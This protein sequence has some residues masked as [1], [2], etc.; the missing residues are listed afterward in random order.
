MVDI[1]TEISSFTEERGC[2]GT[3]ANLLEDILASRLDPA[4]HSNLI[5]I[6]CCEIV[7]IIEKLDAQV[8]E[9]K[10]II[11]N[12]LMNR[13]RCHAPACRPSVTIQTRRIIPTMRT[14]CWIS[15]CRCTFSTAER[16][17][18]AARSF[19][20]RK[21]SPSCRFWPRPWRRRRWRAWWPQPCR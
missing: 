3:I 8:I 17:T 19:R 13:L 7:Q 6:D 11:K 21:K 5:C 9:Y 16:T 15:K 1:Y 20:R 4:R 14:P 2:C 18:T 10:D 12:A